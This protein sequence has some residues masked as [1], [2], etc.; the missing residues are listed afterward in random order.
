MLILWRSFGWDRF[1]MSTD[2][3]FLYLNFL[4]NWIRRVDLLG[5]DQLLV[6]EATYFKGIKT[7][8]QECSTDSQ[9][10]KFTFLRTKIWTCKQLIFLPE[11]WYYFNKL[12]LS[13]NTK[14]FLLIS[15]L[16]H[17][18]LK[19]MQKWLK[20]YFLGNFYHFVI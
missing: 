2:Y 5:P 1:F 10:A 16:Y 9:W 11:L 19:F 4:R 7:L 3:N 20:I 6:W 17:K 15:S 8:G 14:N 12:I 18:I 13:L